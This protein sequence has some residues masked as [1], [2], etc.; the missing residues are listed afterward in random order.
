[1][2]RV[3]VVEGADLYQIANVVESRGLCSSARILAAAKD[4]PWLAELGLPTPSLEGYLAPASYDF[5]R[6]TEPHEILKAMVLRRRKDL[7]AFAEYAPPPP[8]RSVHEAVILAS[9]VEREVRLAA[10]GPLVARV[11]LNRLLDLGGETRGRLQSDPTAVYGCLAIEPS[12]DGCQGVTR[13]A[14]ARRVTPA[15]LRS[16]SNPYN[17]YRHG[18]LPPGPIANPGKAALEAVFRPAAGNQLYFV[19]D[20][21]GGHVFSDSYEEHR[22]VVEG[23]GGG[24]AQGSG[25][26]HFGQ[27]ATP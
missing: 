2:V 1:V 18:G 12:P 14:A 11:F 16:Q 26:A 23:S 22:R 19:A 24:D 3:V 15:M 13:A 4:A 7:V 25:A 9:L 5:F 17:T 20:G 8:L 10:E 21:R 27:P 6:D